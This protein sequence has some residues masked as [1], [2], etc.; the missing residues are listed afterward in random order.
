MDDTTITVA[1]PKRAATVAASPEEAMFLG[2]TLLRSGLLP[3]HIKRPEQAAYIILAGAEMGMPATRALRSLQ[4]V[5]GKIIES[6]DSQL[7]RF[8]ECG[9][10]GQFKELTDTTAE[11]VLRHP[12]G[13]EHVE[14]YT[15]DDAKRAGLMANQVWQKHPRAMLRSRAITAG[16]KSVGWIDAIGAYDPDEAREFASPASALDDAPPPAPAPA[17][18]PVVE[19]AKPGRKS[20][21]EEPA[22]APVVEVVEG[23]DAEIIGPVAGVFRRKDS[24]IYV[25]QVGASK[26]ATTDIEVARTA[27]AAQADSRDV[28]L[29]VT[30]D[31]I[32][33]LRVA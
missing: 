33:Q 7:A 20:K 8:K 13:D 9:G 29:R 6:A 21:K 15:I 26:Y 32:E 2:E 30:G 1:A 3:D 31:T 19:I 27:K 14:T 22:P 18:A 23:T 12:N 5:K 25:V 16:L 17:P 11:L 24:D 4:I 10:R 28:A